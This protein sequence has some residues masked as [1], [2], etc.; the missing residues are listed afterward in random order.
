MQVC[1]GRSAKI[2]NV[3]RCALMVAVYS[4]L[5]S[6]PSQ[7]LGAHSV[8]PEHPINSKPAISTLQQGQGVHPS[9]AC[10]LRE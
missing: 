7:V 1:V 2:T 4:P 10:C 5:C 6:E 8:L 9:V 3:H